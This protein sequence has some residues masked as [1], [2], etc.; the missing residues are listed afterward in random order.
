M[1]HPAKMALYLGMIMPYFPETMPSLHPFSIR[2]MP[3]STTG[4][5]LDAFHVT[6]GNGNVS[7][8][9]VMVR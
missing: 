2:S 1:T 8:G 6:H 9:S 7:A 4:K 5:V 3:E